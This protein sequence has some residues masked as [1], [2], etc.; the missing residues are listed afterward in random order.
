MGSGLIPP[1]DYTY[2]KVAAGQGE[3]TWNDYNGN[4]TKEISEFE[5]AAFAD[6][7]E[8]VKVNLP[9]SNYIKAYTSGFSAAGRVTPSMA[10]RDT[11]GIKSIISCFTLNGSA[12]AEEKQAAF[13]AIPKFF[14]AVSSDNN[15]AHKGT[16]RLGGGFASRNKR[17]FADVYRQASATKQLLVGGSEVREATSSTVN[18]RY[19]P[20]ASLLTSWQGETG[21]STARS[22]LYPSKN[23]K[24]DGTKSLT[25]AE[26]S[27]DMRYSFTLLWEYSEKRNKWGTEK[28]FTHKLGAEALAS[29]AGKMKVEGTFSWLEIDAFAPANSPVSYELLNGLKAGKNAIWTV[30]LSRKLPAGIEINIGYNG[31]YIAD[32]K[33]IHAGSMEVRASF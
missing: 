11:T 26:L 7:A 20:I 24:L 21:N 22:E 23:S 13:S 1:Q 27:I 6:Q 14:P 28:A 25:K 17:Y 19:R 3:Y 10:W 4:G 18:L 2:I 16:W 9:T 30:V 29:I 31:R 33:V 12:Q 5:V 8:Y 32:G 15:I